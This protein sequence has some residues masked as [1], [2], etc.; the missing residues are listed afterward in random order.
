MEFLQ[1]LYMFN[2][3]GK[4]LDIFNVENKTF[5]ITGASSGIGRDVSILLNSVGARLLIT[6][7]NKDKLIETYNM[8]KNKE[9]AAMEAFD[10]SQINLIGDWVK[11]FIKKNSNLIDGFVHCAGINILK[12]LMILTYQDMIDIMNVNFFA[13]MELLRN[14][15]NPKLSKRGSSFVFISSVAGNLGQAGTLSYGASKAALINAVK[16]ASLELARYKFRVN[17]IAPGMIRTP[18]LKEYESKLD[19]EQLKSIEDKFP[20]GLGEPRDV[21]NIVLFLLSDASKWITGA[22]ITV[23]GGYSAGK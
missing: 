8:L 23:D 16:T 1:V 4:M 5:L 7:R 12:P 6:G 17:A 19:K 14:L 13:G 15:A 3:E 11:S 22:T 9:N 18:I 10:L 20:L 2:V 21:S